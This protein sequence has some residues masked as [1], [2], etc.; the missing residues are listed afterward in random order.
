[1]IRDWKRD[2]ELSVVSLLD[3][4]RAGFLWYDGH[5]VDY[6]PYSILWAIQDPTQ[7]YHLTFSHEVSFESVTDHFDSLP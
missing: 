6:S 5:V 3:G 7:V 4:S 2:E 1:M